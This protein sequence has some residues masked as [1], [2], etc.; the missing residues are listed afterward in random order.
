MSDKPTTRCK[1]AIYIDQSYVAMAL[2][3]GYSP[4]Q[5]ETML[6]PPDTSAAGVVH[7]IEE[8]LITEA[9]GVEQAGVDSVAELYEAGGNELHR[10]RET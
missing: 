1:P 6:K 9:E 10:P 8:H 4:E 2:A 3:A 7:A 5:I